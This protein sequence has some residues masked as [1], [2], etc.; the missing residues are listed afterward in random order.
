MNGSYNATF[1]AKCA[2]SG[3]SLN[4][5]LNRI[6]GT[7]FVASTT[8]NPSYGAT[9]GAGWTT[10]NYPFTASETG[11]Q[12]STINYAFTCT[13]TC[14]IQDADVVEDSTLGGNTTV[15]RDA[16][17]YELQKIHPG[18]IRY[19][20]ASLWCSD[21]ADEIA[22]TGNRRWCGGNE[23]TPGLGGPPIG[24]NDVLALGNVVGSDVLLS[25]GLLNGAVR[26]D[27]AD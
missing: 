24:Y 7:T 16:V 6:G 4:F 5:A 11:L 21:V 18:S 27:D 9:P 12:S 3:C 26:L 25:V 14:L 1:K 15:F 23:Y 13:G 8:V 10:Y 19:M 17:V 22:P 2:V 20:D